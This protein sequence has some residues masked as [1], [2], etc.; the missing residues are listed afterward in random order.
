M[1][2]NTDP[3][4]II[5]HAFTSDAAYAAGT[6]MKMSGT[7]GV[8]T[9]AGDEDYLGVLVRRTKASGDPVTLAHKDAPF[10]AALAGGVIAAGAE[11]TTAAD[12]K[13][14]TGAAGAIDPGIALTPSAGDNDTILV[15]RT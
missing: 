6:R 13:L 4:F 8:L 9:A 10:F 12:G 7:F 1:L 5:P 11:V 15:M 2:V 3:S 14:V